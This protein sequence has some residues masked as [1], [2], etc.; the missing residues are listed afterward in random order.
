[1]ALTCRLHITSRGNL[2]LRD[3][4]DLLRNVLT[5]LGIVTTVVTD[6]IPTGEPG[7][8][9]VIV[10]PHEYFVIDTDLPL[11]R[12]QEIASASVL[13]TTEQPGSPFWT[14]QRLICGAAPVT[15]D[16]S[17]TAVEAFR[18]EGV[19]AH[20]L[21]LGYHPS[22]D[23][24]G[25]P[26]E[27]T[28]QGRDID[29]AFLGG[30]SGRRLDA[31]GPSA[32]VLS[33]RSTR[34]LFHDPLVPVRDTTPWFVAG[35]AKA[36][37]LRRS[38]IVLNVHNGDNG[39]F[40][41]IRAI[42]AICNGALLLTE[43]SID[44]GPF[45]AF[46]HFAMSDPELFPA[47][48]TALLAD[49]T[50]RVAMASAAYDLVRSDLRMTEHVRADIVP[51]LE[52]QASRTTP[53][54]VTQTEFTRLDPGTHHAP[55]DAEDDDLRTAL[56]QTRARLRAALVESRSRG[57]ALAR[58]ELQLAGDDP[59]RVDSLATPAWDDTAVP[60]DVSVLVPLHDYAAVVP[61]ALDSVF[62]SRGVDAEVV[63]VDDAS[64]DASADVLRAYLEAHP[65]R[66]ILALFRAANAGPSAARNLAAE[67]A[68]TDRLFLLD[69]D[70]ELYPDGLRRLLDAIDR[71]DAPVAYGILEVFGDSSG[72][73]SSMPW[74]I[75]SLVRRPYIDNMALVT[76]RALD[77]VGGFPDDVLGLEDY[78]FYV[79]LA[80]AGK[81]P[82]WVPQIVGR[83]RLH[84]D[85]SGGAIDSLDHRP[86][87]ELLRSE[88]PDL[89]W[90]VEQP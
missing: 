27:G 60:R 41:W 31:L 18:R 85:T 35:L 13:L 28:D 54:L 77:L 32:R 10:G 49:E 11:E 52:D 53:V 9:D 69:A 78:R 63:I 24:W 16:I 7:V 90:P 33:H 57:R 43:T 71:T 59:D 44:Y 40:E 48:L 1:M 6:G 12:R 51:L 50:R 14:L 47:H 36:E 75:E 34:L 73:V 25:G 42:E 29:V 62:A 66:P 15:I 37:L 88:H 2:F 65:H 81:A 61:E 87:Q 19:T 26:T 5:D 70:N 84:T 58:A 82:E 17:D 79:A 21:R 83:Y 8:A 39:Y 68:R 45:E 20:R 30:A 74:S 55:P 86:V 22:L 80:A 64:T 46:T 76:R 67:A 89:P 38:R 4:A 23:L 72:L 3:L 56:S